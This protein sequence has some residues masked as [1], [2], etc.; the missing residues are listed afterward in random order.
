MSS[1]L[2]IEDNLLLCKMEARQISGAFPGVSV[3]AVH[4]GDDALKAVAAAPPDAVVMDC[5]LPGCGCLDLLDQILEIS[6]GAAVIVASADPPKDLKCRRY[7]DKVFDI[8]EKP[9]E[10]EELIR[11]LKKAFGGEDTDDNAPEGQATAMREAAIPPAAQPPFDRHE[12]INILSGIYVGI[13]AFE[14]ELVTTAD[15]LPAVREIIAE[16]VPKILKMVERA[17]ARVKQVED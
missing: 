14:A 11:V 12:M 16:Y 8:L 17:T 3:Q 7:R 9:F 10:A 5:R 4:N 13:R 6:P 1:V 15:N 2:I